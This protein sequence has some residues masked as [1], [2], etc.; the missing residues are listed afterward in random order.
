MEPVLLAKFCTIQCYYRYMYLCTIFRITTVHILR[1]KILPSYTL[2]CMEYKDVS[3][4]TRWWRYRPNGMHTHTFLTFAP[5]LT[6]SG[7]LRNLHSPPLLNEM[8][9]RMPPSAKQ[10]QFFLYLYLCLYQIFSS[11]KKL[12]VI[13]LFIP[14]SSLCYWRTIYIIRWKT[15]LKMLWFRK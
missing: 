2:G 5:H 4:M 6:F 12:G 10:R 11:I 3:Q 8:T 9:V 7:F 13:G 15:D 1:V 14:L